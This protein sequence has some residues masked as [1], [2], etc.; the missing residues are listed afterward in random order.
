MKCLGLPIRFVALFSAVFC[1]LSLLPSG[2]AQPAELDRILVIVNDDV[3]VRSE[4]E[5]QLRL[6]PL[7]SQAQSDLD[8]KERSRQALEELILSRLQ[9]QVAD[10]LG[11]TV[12][13]SNL[14]E[15]IS[16]IAQ[17][18]NLGL[19][20]FRDALER[21]G[22]PFQAYR[23]KIRKDML[24]MQVS[25]RQIMGRIRVREHEIDDYLALPTNQPETEYKLSHILLAL[26]EQ[27]TGR[28]VTRK[29]QEAKA[30]IERLKNGEDFHQIA[31]I[32]S[33]GGQ[34]RTGGDLGWHLRKD[35]PEIFQKAAVQLSVGEISSLIRSARGFHILHLTDKRGL[36]SAS[37]VIQT[38]ARHILIRTNELVSDADAKLR[39]ER[40]RERIL[41]QGESFGEL[42][43]THSDDR[44]SAIKNGEMGWINPGD[45]V[46]G[47]EKVINALEPNE[48]SQPFRSRF[49]WHIV[50]VQARRNH[51][52]LEEKRRAE[53]RRVLYENK[54]AEESQKWF[55]QL[56]NGAFIEYLVDSYAGV[57]P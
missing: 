25:Q 19:S 21:D 28:S 24:I 15:A 47:F 56:R 11:I 13:D 41:L 2:F 34:A 36:G 39:L 42:A 37:K 20:E 51:D 35:L 10:Q 33:D 5:T 26:P 54:K 29:E 8:K 57:D 55:A 4:L 40:F 44:S 43:Q 45:V 53:A 38:Q 1:V 17:R 27:T 32:F 22:Y 6:S 31:R 46:S 12:S 9:L 52:N 14:N 49:G 18:S 3:I 50:Q 23:D 7:S 16:G 30:L 48:I